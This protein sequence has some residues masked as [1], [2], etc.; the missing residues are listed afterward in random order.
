MVR[1]GGS[2]TKGG[3]YWK[4]G[5]WEVVTI[6]GKSGTLPGREDVEYLW[7]PAVLFGPV[8]LVMGL[9]FYL[10]LPFIGFAMLISVL[11]KKIGRMLAQPT[12]VA[13]T[14]NGPGIL[15]APPTASRRE[16]IHLGGGVS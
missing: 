12:L 15:H 6:Q 5:E 9:A 3:L 7:I 14:G 4:K 8:A 16:H 11:V 1:K 13:N 10:F 2:Q